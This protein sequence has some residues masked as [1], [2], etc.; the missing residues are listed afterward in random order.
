M[1]RRALTIGAAL[2][3]VALLAPLLADFVREVI[4]E[5][6]LYLFFVLRLLYE[7]IP[8]AL[9]WLVFLVAALLVA[10][11][12]LLKEQPLTRGHTRSDER[13]ERVATWAQLIHD[14]EQDDYS[15]WR[16]AHRLESVLVE[17]LAYEQRRTPIEIRRQIE[18]GELPLSPQLQAYLRAGRT[19]Y[20]PFGE[21]HQSRLTALLSGRRAPRTG[22]LEADP[23]EAVDTL[24][25]TLLGEQKYWYEKERDEP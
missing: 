22:P 11:R 5:P 15:R 1:I 13:R 25:Q 7:S 9:L 3:L 10:R 23:R 14:A 17:A 4:A 21:P 20:N 8:Q 12:S 18:R 2:L 16:L 6:V 24:E 19:T